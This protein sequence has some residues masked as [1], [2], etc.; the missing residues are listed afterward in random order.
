MFFSGLRSFIPVSN[1]ID[2]DIYIH[3]NN[4]VDKDLTH[5][6]LVLLSLCQ[7][8]RYICIKACEST[9]FINVPIREYHVNNRL[10]QHYIFS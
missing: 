8:Y 1:V 3:V 10:I 7:A 4:D 6:G 9:L 5:D 2:V